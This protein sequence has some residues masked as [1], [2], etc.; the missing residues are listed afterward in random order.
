[1]PLNTE[2]SDGAAGSKG[3]PAD[4]ADDDDDDW[5]MS[6]TKGGMQCVCIMFVEIQSF[7]RSFHI[8]YVVWSL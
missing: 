2:Q 3:K 6:K 4:T 8:L 1:M 7:W 5:N